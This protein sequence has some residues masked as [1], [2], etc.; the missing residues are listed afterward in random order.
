MKYT[1]DYDSPIDI[2]EQGI[3]LIEVAKKA[4]ELPKEHENRDSIIEEAM[5]NLYTYF[6]TY[7]EKRL[8]N[9][10][11]QLELFKV[12][13]MLENEYLPINTVPF[14]SDNLKTPENVSEMMQFII[15]LTRFDLAKDHNLE[16]DSL[17]KECPNVSYNLEKICESLGVGTIHIGVDHK[18]KYGMFHQFT[19]VR[20]KQE[21]GTYKNY[22]ADCT[23]RQFF[24]KKD[25]NLRRIAVMR[26][27]AAGCSIGAYMMMSDERKEIAETIL[28][29][30][31]IEL[32][33]EVFKEYFDAI[34]FSGRGKDYYDE[35]NLDYMNPNDVKPNYSVD[36]YL[37]TMLQ[38]RV[39]DEQEYLVLKEGLLTDVKMR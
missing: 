19:I 5:N 34:V 23:Y 20:I 17:E 29:Q 22:L 25:S 18:L 13:C 4:I 27:P 7:D 11:L 3:K 30:G 8:Y 31:Y 14:Y 33:P 1:L 32:T 10:K 37:E 36:D 24:T 16:T 2:D 9:F 15:N 21:D 28:T 39:I 12:E 26:G 38:N 35:N 6:S